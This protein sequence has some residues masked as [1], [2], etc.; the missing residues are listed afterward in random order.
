M[1]LEP[2]SLW[3]GAKAVVLSTRGA[4]LYVGRYTTVSIALASGGAWPLRL[5]DGRACPKCA[6]KNTKSDKQHP[7]AV[8]GKDRRPPA[9]QVA[10]HGLDRVAFHRETLVGRLAQLHAPEL[11]ERASRRLL[12]VVCSGSVRIAAGPD[13]T[14]LLPGSTDGGKSSV[15]ARLDTRLHRGV[16]RAPCSTG[17]EQL[18]SPPP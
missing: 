14:V 15:R 4:I 13:I 1:I 12:S 9:V 10:L 11:A 17:C 6:R 3:R 2:F 5:P 7:H 16:R 8:A 18:R